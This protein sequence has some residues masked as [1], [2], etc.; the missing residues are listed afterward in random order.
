MNEL[1]SKGLIKESM[2]P[3]T[4]PILL[5]PK[6]DETK[7]MCVDCCYYNRVESNSVEQRRVVL[8]IPC[9]DGRRIGIPEYHSW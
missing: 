6:K 7:C 1:W 8:I 2:S 3:C 9:Y 4:V 5:V